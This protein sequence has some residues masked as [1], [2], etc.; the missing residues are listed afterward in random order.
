MAKESFD[1]ILNYT[2]SKADLL[3]NMSET[4]TTDIP[5]LS[6]LAEKVIKIVGDSN[7]IRLI[8]YEEYVLLI[9]AKLRYHLKLYLY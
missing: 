1:I 6:F 3:E 7:R 2:H 9:A 8:A 5:G 4:S